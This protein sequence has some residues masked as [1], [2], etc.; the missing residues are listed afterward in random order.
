[1]G[2]LESK[3]CEKCGCPIDYYDHRDPKNSCQIHYFY[4]ENCEHCF[5]NKNGSGNCYHKWSV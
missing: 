2:C 1:M 5:I 4:G 3:H